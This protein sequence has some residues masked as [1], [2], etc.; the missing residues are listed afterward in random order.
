MGIPL[1]DLKRQYVAIKLEIDA[2]ISKVLENTRFIG[3]HDSREL[4][5]G[6]AW[7]CGAK[8]GIGISSGNSWIR[9]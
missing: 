9:L 4:E 6:F 1:I 3:G 2:A 5:S 8:H 7:M